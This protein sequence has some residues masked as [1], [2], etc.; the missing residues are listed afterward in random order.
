M[1]VV[2][3]TSGETLTQTIPQA[4]AMEVPVAATNVGVFQD[5]IQHQETGFLLPPRMPTL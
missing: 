1:F 4:L 3:S 5:I 2:T